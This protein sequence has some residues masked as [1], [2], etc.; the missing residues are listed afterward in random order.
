MNGISFYGNRLSSAQ[1]DKINL[2]SIDANS[3]VAGDQAFT[4]YGQGA[5]FSG[6][7]AAQASLYFDQTAHVLY[8]NNDADATADFSI[9]LV[10]VASLAVGSIVA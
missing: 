4:T 1:G 9:G 7:F 3:A 6:S 2:S 8:G 5:A 10:G